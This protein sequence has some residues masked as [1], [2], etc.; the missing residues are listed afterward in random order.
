MDKPIL[1]V[2][3]NEMLEENLVLLSQT[4]IKLDSHGNEVLIFEGKPVTVYM[5]DINEHGDR[6]NLIASGVVERNNT[7]LF[8]VCKWNC[9]IDH[10][11]IRRESDID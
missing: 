10:N 2:D 1:Y 4:D 7:G 8:P 11:G 6:D 9:R 5:D 3:F